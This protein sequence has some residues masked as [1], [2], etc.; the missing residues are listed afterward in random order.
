MDL[1][2]SV[3]YSV[4]WLSLAVVNAGLAESKGRGRWNWFVW[5][6]LLGPIATYLIVVW[7]R[8]DRSR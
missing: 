5:S 2:Q 6:L 8:L 4:W 7:K 1:T 3:S